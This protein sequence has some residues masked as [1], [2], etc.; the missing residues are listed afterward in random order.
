MPAPIKKCEKIKNFFVWHWDAFDKET[1][2]MK[3]ADSIEEARQFVE[4]KYKGRFV[5]HGVGQIDIV[6]K[7]GNVIGTYQVG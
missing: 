7:K 6:D 5:S 4:D 2:L 1:I 3:E